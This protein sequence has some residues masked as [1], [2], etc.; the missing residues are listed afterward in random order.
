M[1]NITA[2]S[3]IRSSYQPSKNLKMLFYH[4]RIIQV[5]ITSGM[6]VSTL[7]STSNNTRTYNQ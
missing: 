7:V 2:V 5:P 6:Y 1:F 4:L 3:E